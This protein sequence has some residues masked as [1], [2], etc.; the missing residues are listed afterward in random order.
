LPLPF[1]G[2][3]Q[4]RYYLAIMRGVVHRAAFAVFQ[5][6]FQHRVAANVVVPYFFAD[7][8]KIIFAID[9][10]RLPFGIVFRFFNFVIAYEE[11]LADVKSA[12]RF[13]IETFGKEAFENDDHS[14]MEVFVAEMA[15]A[16]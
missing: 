11:A 10:H 1:D 13:H 8:L 16:S 15:M 9:E 6:F 4:C 2:M 5:V 12:V 7:A 3:R 14:I